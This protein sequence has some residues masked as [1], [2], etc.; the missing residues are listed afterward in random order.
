[1]IR[2]AIFVAFGLMA[3][4]CQA[5]ENGAPD[6]VFAAIPFDQ[7]LSQSNQSRIHWTLH[8]SEP[9]LSPHQ[10]FAVDLYVEVD[11]A[12]LAK[13]RDEGRFLVLVQLTDEKHRVWQNHQEANKAALTQ[14]FFV[15][16]GNYRI[17]VAL[18][19]SA[20]G[21]H[22]V[23]QRTLHVA[24]LKNDPL[25]EMWR[26]LPAVEFFAADSPPGRWYLP[27]VGGRL[28]MV[29]ETQHPVEVDLLV[30]LTPA[31]RLAASTRIQSRNLDALIPATKVL[32]QVTWRNA[33]LNI[34]WFDLA[35]RRV[36]YQ[37]DNVETLD[38]PKAGSALGEV[39][40]GVIDVKSL[41]DRKYM[42]DFFLNRIAR[43]VRPFDQTAQPRRVVI[44][45]SAT[46][47]FDSGVD[48]HPIGIAPRPDVTL[49]YVRYQPRP[50]VVLTLD[51][52]PRRIYSP[53]LGDQLAPLLKPLA[54]R[55]FEVATPEQFRKS[56]AQLLELIAKL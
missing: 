2:L 10:R 33:K 42:A 53:G 36:T 4:P 20:S 22:S 23:I 3:A 34:E 11:A 55:L 52:R 41:E 40:P 37:Q 18:F 27:S 49:I 6:P 14:S 44:V 21:D 45:L 15:L 16:P 56:L 31:E 29:V 24:A 46:V 48:V 28:K 7:W 25:P 13:R 30:N 38:W 39:N 5:E 12:V 32:T 8:M 51:G 50:R 43:R 35:R 17:A 9:E 47:F 1:M 54:P 19:D 26:D